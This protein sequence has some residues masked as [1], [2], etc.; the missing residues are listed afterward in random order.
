ME[1]NIYD[2]VRVKEFVKI[3]EEVRNSRLG[4]LSGNEGE[5][6]DKLW[7][8]SL[9]KYVYVIH[10][11]GKAKPSPKLFTEEMLEAIIAESAEYTYEFKFLG[12]VVLAVF[13]EEVGGIKREVARGH[14]HILHEGALGIAQASSYAMKKVYEKMNG[15]NL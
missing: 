1:F 2:R 12:N 8:D 7:S 5:V 13:Y 11:Y 15:G 4:A 14:G 6:C 3:P 9:S 10:F